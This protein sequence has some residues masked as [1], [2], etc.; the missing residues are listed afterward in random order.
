MENKITL[1]ASRAQSATLL[2]AFPV[3]PG[4]SLTRW[5]GDLADAMRTLKHLEPR[6]GVLVPMGMEDVLATGVANHLLGWRGLSF[7][8]AAR[9]VDRLAMRDRL[10]GS[11]NPSYG[12]APQWDDGHEPHVCAARAMGA[13]RGVAIYED[14]DDA[15]RAKDRVLHDTTQDMHSLQEAHTAVNIAIRRPE[16]EAIYEVFMPGPQHEV[17]G[18]VAEPG[19]LDI[20]WPLE[21]RWVGGKILEYHKVPASEGS[22]GQAKWLMQVASQAV[23]DLGLAWCGFR[24]E[25]RSGMVVRVSA[26]LG[27]DGLGYDAFLRGD[28]PSR[29]HRMVAFLRNHVR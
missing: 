4:V 16:V 19:A 17:S 15:A 25:I 20:W 5:S 14:F 8:A 9:T 7:E 24:V 11:L 18:V 21:Q 23:V 26:A 2:K 10:N 29:Y 3:G 13:S 6:P 12:P 22:H 27:K 28:H 1:L